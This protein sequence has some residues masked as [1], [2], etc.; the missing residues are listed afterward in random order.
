MLLPYLLAGLSA[1]VV[2]DYRAASYMI[3]GQ[4]AAR[5]TFTADLASGSYPGTEAV[6]MHDVQQLHFV[7]NLRACSTA[8]CIFCTSCIYSPGCQ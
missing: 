6:C 2:A 4:L 1:S 5:A 7:C 3:I 8:A